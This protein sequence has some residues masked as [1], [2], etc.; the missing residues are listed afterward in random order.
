M[1]ATRRGL[2]AVHSAVFLFGLTA[3]F[4]KLITLSA[5]EITLL[6]ILNARGK[7]LHEKISSVEKGLP[8]SL[9][10]RIRYI[11]TVRNKLVHEESYRKM[12]DRASFRR[13]VKYVNKELKRMEKTPVSW[14]MVSVIV[15]V[16]LVFGSLAAMFLK[17][18]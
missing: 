10:E 18:V 7:G 11:A 1:N 14:L 12:D 8:V 5:M 2:W 13:A 15:L 3:L 6:R 16:V 9:V 17:L 4:S